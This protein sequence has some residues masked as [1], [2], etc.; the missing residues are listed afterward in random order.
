MSLKRVFGVLL[1]ELY[2]TKRSLEVIMD[3]FF[4]PVINVIVFGF[5]SSFLSGGL[6][7]HAANYLLMGMILWQA[8]YITQ[9]SISVGS[10]WNIWS[11]N[12]SNM[13]ITP[14]SITEYL[15]AH[16]LSG[17]FKAILTFLLFAGL[18]YFMFDFNIFQLGFVNLSLY[19]VNLIIFAISTG[20]LIL[21]AIFRYG[22]RIQALAWGLI[23]LFQ[24]L[25]AALFP[26]SVLPNFLQKISLFFPVTYIFEAAR[27][28]LVEPGIQWQLITTATIENVIYLAL[29][30]IFFQLMFRKAKDTGQFARN[31]G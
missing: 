15:S 16:I 26:I 22:T 29:S 25:T 14:L 27:K 8:I 1:Q 24:P 3:I 30:I 21:G 10:L 19:F 4:F 7:N 28:S 31:E 12:L 11:R 17:I 5:I 9:Y 6:N 20:I 13:F 18:G 23:F 2:I